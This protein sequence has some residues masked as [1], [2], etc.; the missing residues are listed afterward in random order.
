MNKPKTKNF[1]EQLATERIERLFQLASE[2]FS[3]NPH[4]S[5]EW[6]KLAL[7]IGTRNRVRMPDQLKTAYC[8]KC[9]SFLVEGK[10]KATTVQKNWIMIECQEC[11]QRFK[12]KKPLNT[13]RPQ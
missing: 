13:T 5:H 2:E 12:R 11:H 7:R 4:Y 6:T 3:Y 1:V 8:K 10:N 9:R